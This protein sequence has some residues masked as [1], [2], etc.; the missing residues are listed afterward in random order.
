[1]ILCLS[2]ATSL[3]FGKVIQ[4][5]RGSHSAQEKKIIEG[6]VFGAEFVRPDE[7]SSINNV[8]DCREI[9]ISC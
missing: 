8:R 5:F 1:M 2:W 7:G 9:A 3:L 4:V 6:K